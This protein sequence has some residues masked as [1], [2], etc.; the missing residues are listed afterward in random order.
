MRKGDL[1]KGDIPLGARNLFLVAGGLIAG[2]DET[3]LFDAFNLGH[4]AVM[5]G[6]LDRSEAETAHIQADN[7]KPVGLGIFR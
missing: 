5:D 7:L 3:R 6:D 4:A 2:S 1:P